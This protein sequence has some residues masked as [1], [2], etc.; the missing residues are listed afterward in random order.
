MTD[1]YVVTGFLESGKTT[2]INNLIKRNEWQD[3]SIL[4][5]QFEFGEEEIEPFQKD[6]E[7]LKFYK[8]DV[9]ASLKS[10][11]EKIHM[12]LENKSYDEIWV[13][14]NGTTP[15]SV[16]QEIFLS[17]QLEKLC[18]IKKVIHI[19]DAQSIEN[20][21]GKT[22]EYLPEQISLCDFAVIRNAD[23]PKKLKQ[24]YKLFSGL[25]PG[26]KVFNITEYEK[27]Y[28]Y[29]FFRKNKPIMNFF[30]TVLFASALYI[31]IKP[32]LE[33]L[34]IPINSTVNIFLGVILQAIPFLI[35][36]VLLSSAIQIFVS[37][38]AIERL[39]PKSMGLG[40][41]TAVFCGFLLPVCDC[42]SIPIFRSLVKKGVPLCVAVTFMTASPVIN[43]VVMLSTYYAFGGNI[44]IV[45]GRV[46]LGIISS[47]I[48][49]LIIGIFPSKYNTLSNGSFDRIMCSCGCFSDNVISY[50]FK[51]KLTL[52]LR[53]SKAEFFSVG[54]Y[55]VIGTLVSSVFQAMGKGLFV[56]LQS[57]SGI[58]L[59]III[60][61]AMAF[62][63][64][65]CSSSD[66]VVARSFLNQFPLPAI[67]GFLIFGP[68]MDIK[69]VMMLNF[70]FSK[71]FILKLSI[72]TFTVCFFVA[73]ISTFGGF[74]NA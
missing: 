38:E 53:H 14:A 2:F 70:G 23:S 16:L 63:L 48:I 9:E 39:F 62:V 11:I 25:N 69:N 54:K 37:K 74:I 41:I 68:M 17:P 4:F 12:S 34:N 67:M 36:G 56:N 40:M 26:I 27:I 44:S 42:A 52:F 64:S 7:I 60:M 46:L 50:T 18:K 10:V 31:F 1:I 43:P 61:M 3:I 6:F 65:L 19:A 32:F 20:L 29:L 57:G 66:A 51:N 47:L 15:F 71:K 55:L 45:L 8:K 35:I 73:L 5:I 22:G 72:L 13:E 24:I 59:S 49:G 28:D 30:L 58:I 21:L 33:W